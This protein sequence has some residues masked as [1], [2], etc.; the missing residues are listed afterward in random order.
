MF[1]ARCGDGRARARAARANQTPYLDNG[2]KNVGLPRYRVGAP[3]FLLHLK[4]FENSGRV[5]Q[6]KRVNHSANKKAPQAGGGEKKLREAPVISHSG[7]IPDGRPKTSWIC[8]AGD[9]S[10]AEARPPSSGPSTARKKSVRSHGGQ[11]RHVT[12]VSRVPRHA[13]SQVLP[14]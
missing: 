9:S 13:C 3:A 5:G 8:A 4:R 12:H 6:D 10:G 1:S 14:D 7:R 11:L 2:S